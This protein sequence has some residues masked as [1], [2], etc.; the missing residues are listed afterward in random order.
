MHRIMCKLFLL[1]VVL[2]SFPTVTLA[3]QADLNVDEIVPQYTKG[4]V[5]EIINT[6]LG[7]DL[8]S[9]LTM[10]QQTLNVKITSGPFKD[11]VITTE[12]STSGNV[13]YD[14]WLAEGDKV[15]LY[16]ETIDGE[17]INGH[18]MD[19]SRDTYLFV[20]IA[21]FILVL[22][23]IGKRQG[24]KSVITLGFTLLVIGKFLL[25]LLFR[26][27]NPVLL[28][29]ISGVI[30]ATVT[31]L[32]IGGI[33]KKSFAAILGTTG[34]L[35]TAVTISIIFGKLTNLRGLSDEEVQMLMYIPQ[36]I[37]FDFQGLLFAGMMIG[38][39]GAVMDVS[40]SIASAM[41]E[42]K[43]VGNKLSFKELFR[44]GM[45]VG[46]DIMG[47]MSNT[48]I[49][50]YTGAS[51]PLLLLLMAYDQ[52]LV[53]LINM[54]FLAIEVIRALSGSIGLILAIPI[55]AL[56]SATLMKDKSRS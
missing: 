27:Y 25:P 3:Q 16:L 44:S 31:F 17:L 12:N 48:L 50:A 37:Q 13:A 28:A 10:D 11:Q 32:I 8:G 42:I 41:D 1:V 55:T 21:V 5:L 7:K 34:G 26:G 54:D 35:L 46:K 15:L 14:I 39:L 52:P 18:V 4:Q 56:I 24:L 22:I 29:L 43:N 38:A 36:G 53:K 9:G 45:N 49:L 20:L 19:F 40:I 23:A 47:T 33:T 6:E 2:M 51:I 30:I